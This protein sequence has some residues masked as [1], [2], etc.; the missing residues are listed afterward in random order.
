MSETHT[1]RLGEPWQR[2]AL[3][4]SLVRFTRNFGAPRTL[5]VG[6]RV[7]L[8][9]EVLPSGTVTLNGE[10]L[11]RATGTFEFDITGRVLPRNRLEIVGQ[12]LGAIRLEIRIGA[13]TE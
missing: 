12:T 9:G 3:E 1:I 4:H 6:E 13:R 8:C 11:G 2:E 7:W 10:E 5:P